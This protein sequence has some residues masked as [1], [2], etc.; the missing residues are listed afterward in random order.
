[1]NH[2]FDERVELQR[3]SKYTKVVVAGDSNRSVHSFIE[4]KTGNLLKAASWKAPAKGVRFNLLSD[5]DEL[6]NRIDPYGSYLYK[7]TIR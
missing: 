6:Q 1:M 3:G 7:I 2:N 4:N 5:M